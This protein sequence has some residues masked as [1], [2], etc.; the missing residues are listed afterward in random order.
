MKREGRAELAR[1]FSSKGVDAGS[2]T[3]ASTGSHTYASTG[4]HTYASTGSHKD[5]GAGS[6]KVRVKKC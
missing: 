2:Y 5:V 1:P 4:S 3:Y 6:H